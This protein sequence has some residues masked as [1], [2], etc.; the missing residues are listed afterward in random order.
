MAKQYRFFYHYFK[1]QKKMSVHFR[2]KCSI[3]NDIVCKTTCE[4][5][6]RKTQPQ[7]VMQGFAKNVIIENDIAYIE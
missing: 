7:L 4:T 3:V 6:W 2:N 5:K 1:A